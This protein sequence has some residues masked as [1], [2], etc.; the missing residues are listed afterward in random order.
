MVGDLIQQVIRP[1]KK[2]RFAHGTVNGYEVT[3]KKHRFHASCPNVSD[4]ILCCEVR[5]ESEAGHVA[6]DKCL[7]QKE[8]N[9][10]FE[11][12]VNKYDLEEVDEE[13]YNE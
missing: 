12:L 11:Y 6:G 7:N 3:I 2:D 13:E 9:E 8:G 10:M 5:T 4:A 1:E